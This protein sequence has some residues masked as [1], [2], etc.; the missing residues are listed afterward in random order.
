MAVGVVAPALYVG[1][2]YKL[3][4]A[5]NVMACE[6][7][8]PQ[9]LFETTGNKRLHTLFRWVPQCRGANWEYVRCLRHGSFLTLKTIG[10]LSHLRMYLPFLDVQG[11]EHY[12]GTTANT[13][14]NPPDIVAAKSGVAEEHIE[15]P[16]EGI[17]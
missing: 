14:L 17:D 1:S 4:A 8:T 7:G 5:G 3:R 9:A 11:S 16:L 15:N 6:G 13:F 12:R 2:V 10:F